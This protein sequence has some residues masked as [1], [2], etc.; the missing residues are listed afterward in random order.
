MTGCAAQTEPETFRDMAE[1]VNDMVNGHISVK[2]KAMACTS[3]MKQK[4]RISTLKRK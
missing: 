2:K 3:T 1:G 4:I